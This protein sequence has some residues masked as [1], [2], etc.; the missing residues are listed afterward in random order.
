MDRRIDDIDGYRYKW[1]KGKR[2]RRRGSDKVDIAART[3]IIVNRAN[4]VSRN[5]GESHIRMEEKPFDIVIRIR[6]RVD[7]RSE[8]NDG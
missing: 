6:T 2:E 5:R 8:T 4:I 7:T 3:S 1:T